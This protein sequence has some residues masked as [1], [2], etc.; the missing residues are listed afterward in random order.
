M[1]DDVALDF[2]FEELRSYYHTVF[3]NNKK[4][5]SAAVELPK[6]LQW[7]KLKLIFSSEY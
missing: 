3:F 1:G 7:T 6:R 2:L 5:R 4:E